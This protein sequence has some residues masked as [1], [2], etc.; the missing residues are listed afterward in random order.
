MSW[1]I[2]VE[3]HRLYPGSIQLFEWKGIWVRS[4][5]RLGASGAALDGAPALD[6]YCRA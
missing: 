1:R 3:R 4:N 5:V 6:P 2:R